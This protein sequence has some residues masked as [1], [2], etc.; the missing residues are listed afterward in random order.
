MLFGGAFEKIFSVHTCGELFSSRTASRLGGSKEPV[1]THPSGNCH[2][3]PESWCSTLTIPPPGATPRAPLRA[4]QGHLH[5]LGLIAGREGGVDRRKPLSWSITM[6]KAPPGQLKGP[7]ADREREGL[8]MPWAQEPMSPP[9]R[10]AALGDK[11]TIAKG[12]AGRTLL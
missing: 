4:C 6:R 3:P 8:C 7:A 11:I 2:Q 5:P 10:E 9:G 12:S 1:S